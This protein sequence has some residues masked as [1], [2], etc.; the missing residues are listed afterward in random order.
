VHGLNPDA[1]AI[2]DALDKERKD[3]GVRGPL[4]GIPVLIKDNIDTADKM[5][6]TAGSLALWGSRPSKDSTVAQ[7]LRE[8]GAVI[9]GKQ[10]SANGPTFVPATHQRLERPRRPDQEPVCAGPQPVRFE[11]RLGRRRLRESVRCSHRHGNR[12]I[13]RLPFV[14]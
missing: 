2:A 5:M 4:H 8:A 11:F 12:R 9:L 7:K 10:I 14:E 1:L 6:T 3:K 13:D